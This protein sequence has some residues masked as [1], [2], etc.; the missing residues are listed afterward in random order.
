VAVPGGGFD[1]GRHNDFR[2]SWVSPE[3]KDIKLS[4]VKAILDEPLV[5]E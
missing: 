3:T 1:R 5:E 4:E 2:E